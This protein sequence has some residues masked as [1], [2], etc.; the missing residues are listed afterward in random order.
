MKQEM[1]STAFE[2]GIQIKIKIKI[3]SEA[4]KINCSQWGTEKNDMKMFPAFMFYLICK[5]H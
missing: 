1:L 5:N 2:T 4:H 3:K